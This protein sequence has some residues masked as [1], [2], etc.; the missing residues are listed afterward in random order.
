M[1]YTR[2]HDFLNLSNPY[3]ATSQFERSEE[4]INIELKE[5]EKVFAYVLRPGEDIY[6]IYNTFPNE[7]PEEL[8]FPEASGY[9]D[10]FLAYEDL[11]DKAAKEDGCV[12]D[13]KEWINSK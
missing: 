12:P 10:I 8:L 7:S 2:K 9:Y 4:Y 6:L 5:P 11:I 13:K 1:K 3:K